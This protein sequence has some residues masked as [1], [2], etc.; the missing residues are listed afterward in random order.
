MSRRK[1]NAHISEHENLSISGGDTLVV[2]IDYKRPAREQ[3]ERTGFK[4]LLEHL[5]GFSGC[6][7]KIQIKIVC[8]LAYYPGV[9]GHTNRPNAIDYGEDTDHATQLFTEM[10]GILNGFKIEELDVEFYLPWYNH[11]QLHAVIPLFSLKF[12]EWTLH[13]ISGVSTNGQSID[14]KQNGNGIFE[15]AC[16]PFDYE[17]NTLTIKL[18]SHPS[19]GA[20]ERERRFITLLPLFVG[21]AKHIVIHIL[22]RS[23]ER[24]LRDSEYPTFKR[25]ARDVVRIIDEFYGV[26]SVIIYVKNLQSTYRYFSRAACF[27]DF[28]S[29]EWKFTGISIPLERQI[30]YLYDR[31]FCHMNKWTITEECVI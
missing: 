2:T 12:T 18:N 17:T 20:I 5:P 9:Y 26:G 16:L 19:P 10:R 31:G 21:Y 25:L 29:T 27:H 6:M 13:Y 11:R 23:G 7:K 3:S 30:K 24:T 14:V 1:D 22:P 28:K 4:S 15:H 8:R